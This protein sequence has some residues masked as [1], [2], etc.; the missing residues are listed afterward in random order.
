MAYELD[1]IEH[2]GLV[3]RIVNDDCSGEPDWMSEE[4]F[5]VCTAKKYR[6]GIAA[7]TPP[8]SHLAWGE[9][10]W[11]EYGDEIPG[12][13][14]PG[15]ESEAYDLYEQ[16]KEDHDPKY[17]VWPFRCGDVHGPGSFTISIMDVEDTRR[18]DPD[19]WIYVE[20]P[21]SPLEMLAHPECDP[22]K[23]RDTCIE[24]YEQWAN[25]DIWG[26]IVEDQDG[27]ELDS[28]WGFYGTEHCIESAKEEASHL[29]KQTK[30][31]TLVTFTDESWAFLTVTPPLGV[32]DSKVCEWALEH[33]IRDPEVTAAA[34]VT[35]VVMAP[36]RTPMEQLARVPT[37]EEGQ[38]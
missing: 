28:C 37:E 29:V 12:P 27:N 9:G 10:S 15:D 4:V 1:R 19:G 14:A 11:G 17:T 33:V 20:T 8:E 31:L 35:D 21:T 16:W 24:V 30:K 7:P 26:Y 13:P 18:I 34:L 36:Q 3:I 22:E 5:L 2:E 32:P 25:G 23:L 38:A 6:F